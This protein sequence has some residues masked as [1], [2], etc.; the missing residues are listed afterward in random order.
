MRGFAQRSVRESLLFAFVVLLGSLFHS[1][2][3]PRP[4]VWAKRRH[5]LEVK[6]A[7]C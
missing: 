5:R 1:P 6:K 7:T 3:L 2:R 4:L